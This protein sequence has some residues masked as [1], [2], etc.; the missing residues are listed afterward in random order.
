M[1]EKRGKINGFDRLT[2]NP[3]DF[4]QDK[5]KNASDGV[6]SVLNFALNDKAEGR[7]TVC[8]VPSDSNLDDRE[9][10]KPIAQP[11]SEY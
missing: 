7:V 6:S 11:Q 5:A 8:G 4:A 9:R 3:F 2:I 10:E 1:A